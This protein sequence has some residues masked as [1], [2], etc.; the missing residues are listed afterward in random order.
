MGSFVFLHMA[1]CDIYV[2]MCDIHSYNGVYVED[3]MDS[4]R[5]EIVVL[6]MSRKL[7]K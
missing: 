7:A 1:V 6:E 5:K 2:C 4:T 3:F